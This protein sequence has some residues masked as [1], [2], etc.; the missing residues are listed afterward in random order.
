MSETNGHNA[1]PKPEW[2]ERLDRLDAS[3]VKLMTDFEVFVAE[4]EKFVLEQERAWERHEKWAVEQ[5]RYREEQKDRDRVLDKRIA[6]LVS[7]IGAFIQ[8]AQTKG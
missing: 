2:L 8:Q 7:G 6:E 4:H 3:H 1:N 5:E